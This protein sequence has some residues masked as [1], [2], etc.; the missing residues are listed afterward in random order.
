VA[1]RELVDG[2]GKTLPQGASDRYTR[3][4]ALEKMLSGDLYEHLNFS[5]ET[6]KAPGQGYVPIRERRP[7]VDFNLAYEI[8]QDTL[9]EIFGDE[10]FPTLAV[11]VNNDQDEDASKAVTELIG[12]YGLNFPWLMAQAYEEGVVGGVGV[13]VYRGADGLPFYD[14]LPAKWCEPVYAER[15]N[16]LLALV[17]TYPITADQAEAKFP[18]ITLEVGNEGQTT[19]WYRYI[20]GP[21]VVIDYRP[22]SDEQ[23]AELGEKDDNGDVIQF[24]EHLRTDHGFGA[25]VPAVYV[26]HP[27]GKQ[28]DTEGPALW[29]PIRNICVEADYTLSQAGR[30]LR[31]AADPMLFIKKSGL[32]GDM[33][34]GPGG[35]NDAAEFSKASSAQ[36]SDDGDSVR[37]VGQTIV[38]DDAKLLEIS[39]NGISEEREYVRD[40]REY[41]LEVI[42]GMKARAEHLKGAASGTAID[43]GLKPL[44]RLVRRLRGPYGIGLLLGVLKLTLHGIR[45]N[46]FDLSSLGIDTVAIPENA[47]ITLDWPNDE[48]LKGQELFYHV[49]GLQLAAG[50][51]VQAPVQLISPETIGARLSGDLGFHDAYDTIKGDLQ[52]EVERNPP[53]AP[54][55]GNP[56]PP[57]RGNPK[58]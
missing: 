44:R 14:V 36:L 48:T 33:N 47:R 43:K 23:F 12:P 11:L 25:V 58:T 10:Q 51:T 34:I 15:S 55:S 27:G 49:E 5:F 35:Y 16:R 56:P 3:L 32:V 28:R 45:T 18:G 54:V 13:A 17:V 4:T 2:L 7:S 6:E 40:L 20:I 29:W 19:Y 37:G 57:T 53:P 39:A 41:A 22:L 52:T 1:F 42:G 31:Y 24:S 21:H 9:A 30:G 26:K 50:G 8:T 46:V 38:G